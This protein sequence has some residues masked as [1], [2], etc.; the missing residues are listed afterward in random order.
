MWWLGNSLVLRQG[1]RGHGVPNF[2]AP[3]KCV[4]LRFRYVWK[5]FGASSGY[6]RHGA[7]YFRT[8]HKYVQLRSRNVWKPFVASSRY[9]RPCSTSL[10]NTLMFRMNGMPRAQ[11]C[12]GAAK[13]IH[14][15]LDTRLPRQ[16]LLRCSTSRIPAVVSRTVLLLNPPTP[17]S[18]SM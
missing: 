11:G 8:P 13:H 18:N 5:L 12:A 7:P 16:L 6:Q 2:R 14:V 17:A 10:Q 3:H 1:M 9:Q 4:R 15:S